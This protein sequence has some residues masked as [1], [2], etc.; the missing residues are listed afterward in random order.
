MLAWP[1]WACKPTNLPVRDAVCL[2]EN[3]GGHRHTRRSRLTQEPS[4]TQ[5][6]SKVCRSQAQHQS[7]SLQGS[8]KNPSCS[9]LAA[10][11]T[12]SAFSCKASTGLV[13]VC[14]QLGGINVESLNAC[15]WS[16]G[17]CWPAMGPGCN[18]HLI[19]RFVDPVPPPARQRQSGT[20]PP[21]HPTSGKPLCSC[22]PTSSMSAWSG[23]CAGS[24]TGTTGWLPKC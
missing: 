15:I 18:L 23:W 6:S 7:I 9:L 8:V 5:C 16:P 4:E 11:A 13:G 20:T 2:G 21:E 12:F 24:L 17:A 14:Q 22:S 10:L 3:S 19:S 1:K